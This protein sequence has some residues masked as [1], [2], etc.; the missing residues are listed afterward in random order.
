[1][2]L[3]SHHGCIMVTWA[4]NTDTSFHNAIILLKILTLRLLG[5]DSHKENIKH[6]RASDSKICSFHVA[7]SEFSFSPNYINK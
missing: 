5:K 1:M 4:H 7:H 2:N 3:Y 6:T